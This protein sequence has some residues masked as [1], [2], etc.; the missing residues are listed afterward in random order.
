[1]RPVLALLLLPWLCVGSTHA[2]TSP[3]RG[4]IAVPAATGED[5]PLADY[6]GLL[7]QIAPAA[8]EGAQAYLQAFHKRCGRGMSAAELRRAIADQNGDPVLMQMIRASHVNDVVELTR[9]AAQVPC[10]RSASR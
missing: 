5:I 3:A 8:R 6:L 9:L 7:E 1:M 2:Q 10:P 4:P